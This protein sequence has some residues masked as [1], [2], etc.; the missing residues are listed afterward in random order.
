M[1][2]TQTV[3]PEENNI[4]NRLWDIAQMVREG[5]P[6]PAIYSDDILFAICI[7]KEQQS[8]LDEYKCEA[9]LREV[10]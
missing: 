5:D 8:E 10:S 3:S 7:L 6:I 1:S 4:L 2:I 9:I